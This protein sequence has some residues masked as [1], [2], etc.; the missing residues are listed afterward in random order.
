MSGPQRDVGFHRYGIKLSF[1]W[2]ENSTSYGIKLSFA[3]N[4]NSTSYGIK[5]SFVWDENRISYG[6]RTVLYIE[7]GL[8]ALMK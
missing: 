4:E 3:W 1:A 7:Q 5:L 8:S 6:M 2:N